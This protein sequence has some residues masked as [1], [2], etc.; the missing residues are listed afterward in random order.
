MI[1][2]RLL[3][4]LLITTATFAAVPRFT[5]HDIALTA[6]GN[7]GNPYVEVSAEATLKRPD[8]TTAT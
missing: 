8:R 1:A 3:V 6:S 2:Q 7:Y 5:P 4:L